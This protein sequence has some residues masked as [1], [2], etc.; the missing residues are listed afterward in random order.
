[1]KF[2]TNVMVSDPCYQVGTWCQKEL[3]NVLPGEYT[4]FVHESDQ[5]GWGRRVNLLMVVKNE[6]IGVSLKW[7]KQR[8]VDIGVDSGQCGFF[9]INGYRNDEMAKTITTGLPDW[10]DQERLEEPGEL[11]YGK[12][13]YLTNNDDNPTQRYGSYESGVVSS[14]GFGDGSYDL[15]VAR[16]EKRQIIGIAVHYSVDSVKDLNG[17]TINY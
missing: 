4:P 14:S 10:M 16:N 5:G 8:G 7:N 6:Y 17:L 12:M 1:M 3:K 11:F 15:Y 13:C 2:G 9:D